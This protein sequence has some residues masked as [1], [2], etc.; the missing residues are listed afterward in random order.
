MKKKE[1]KFAV[2]QLIVEGNNPDIEDF[3]LIKENDLEKYSLHYKEG[4][5]EKEEILSIKKISKNIFNNRFIGFYSEEG[6]KFPYSDKVINSELNEVDNPRSPEE[7]ELKN[8]FFCLVD[9]K[10]G[11]IYISDQRKKKLLED[12]LKKKIKK[13]VII[14]PLMLEKDFIDKVTSLREISFSVEPNLLNAYNFGTLSTELSQD[15]FGFGAQEA[16]IKLIY[17]N[18]KISKEIIEKIRAL[19][20]RKKD[21][22]NITIIGRTSD[23]FESIFNIDEII[24]KVSIWIEPDLNTQKIDCEIVFNSL[25]NNIKTE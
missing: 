21:F 16:I 17:K 25:I 19:I 24:N 5:K 15:I 4:Q 11:R 6:D 14:K 23:E 20:G 10:T 8:Q 18:K 13:D 22:K 2:N 1:L 3:D 9:I 7:I 12:W